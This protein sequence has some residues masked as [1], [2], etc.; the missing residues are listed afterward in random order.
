MV[1]EVLTLDVYDLDIDFDPNYGGWSD[2]ND[3][4]Q[5]YLEIID[6][7]DGNFMSYITT[8]SSHQPYSVSSTLGDKYLDALSEDNIDSLFAEYES[9]SA[10]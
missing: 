4:M 3:L 8:V 10:D 6:S 5:K 2:D 7:V 9:R 1:G